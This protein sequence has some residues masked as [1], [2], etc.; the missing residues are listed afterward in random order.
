MVE[1]EGFHACRLNAQLI[2]TQCPTTRMDELV[3]SNH[4]MPTSAV[5]GGYG[6]M[7]LQLLRGGLGRKNV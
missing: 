3:G 1:R 7:Q 2:F 6:F 5:V 4:E